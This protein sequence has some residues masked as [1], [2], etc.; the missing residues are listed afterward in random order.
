VRADVPGAADN[1]AVRSAEAT[2]DMHTGANG[3]P[4]GSSAAHD[5][6]NDR[7]DLSEWVLDDELD[8]EELRQRYYGLLQELRVVLPG[9]QV[10]MAFLLTVPFAQRFD[11]LDDTERALF[12]VALGASVLSVV[13]FLAPTAYHRFGD[14][15]H[16]SHRLRMGI[17]LTRVGLGFLAVS[18]LS[19][20]AVVM[21]YVYGDLQA[22]LAVGAC[23]VVMLVMWVVVPVTGR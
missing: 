16:R 6:P 14:R 21:R 17:R 22:T 15:R 1:D 10:L 13:S 19:A 2:D 8:R 18:L 9:V 5:S 11:A 12:A 7:S 3:S 23:A 20:L 4:E